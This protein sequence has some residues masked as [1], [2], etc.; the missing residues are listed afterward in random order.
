MGR[1]SL[2]DRLVTTVSFLHSRLADVAAGIGG[3]ASMAMVMSFD[4]LGSRAFLYPPA[5]AA[6]AIIA[7]VALGT[8]DWRALL[9]GI[10]AG[11]LTLAFLPVALV[12]VVMLAFLL[13]GIVAWLCLTLDLLGLP[14]GWCMDL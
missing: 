5:A 11:I 14:S 8:R 10:G 13:E 12:A 6:V 1:G 2:S 7:A 3:V 9:T 4:T